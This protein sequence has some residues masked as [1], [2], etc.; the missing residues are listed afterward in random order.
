VKWKGIKKW[1]ARLF[2]YTPSQRS[3]DAAKQELIDSMLSL[4]AYEYRP[5]P[6][7]SRHQRAGYLYR[8]EH[9]IGDEDSH[10]PP[11]P[12]I[13]IAQ[14]MALAMLRGYSL[15][16]MLTSQD[17]A[18]LWAAVISAYWPL[19]HDAK[20]NIAGLRFGVGTFDEQAMM[21]M[22]PISGWCFE[23]TDEKTL[24]IRVC[25]DNDIDGQIDP[26]LRALPNT[27][28]FNLPFLSYG[29][30]LPTY[31]NMAIVV[32]RPSIGKQEVVV[33]NGA[34]LALSAG[35]GQT[36]IYTHVVGGWQESGRILADWRS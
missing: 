10:I 27:T 3:S 7:W 33:Y 17:D 31:P 24:K 22:Q 5:N 1:L 2:G 6:H 9:G 19:P 11:S 14:D 32:E 4:S 26:T 34:Q 35:L 18:T 21:K 20:I 25:H 15:D 12:A 8:K 16:T 28:L 36:G 30:E 13:L 23:R 29:N